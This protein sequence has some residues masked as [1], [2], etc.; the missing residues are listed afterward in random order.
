METRAAGIM[1]ACVV[2]IDGLCL[3]LIVGGLFVKGRRGGENVKMGW[4]GN[5]S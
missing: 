4:E 5:K 3:V 2:G 1:S